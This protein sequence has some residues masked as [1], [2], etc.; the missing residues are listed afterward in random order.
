MGSIAA[1]L[2]IAF[3]IMGFIS[4]FWTVYLFFKHDDPWWSTISVIIFLV[5]K[6]KLLFLLSIFAVILYWSEETVFV[7]FHLVFYV[8]TV[9]FFVISAIFDDNQGY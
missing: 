9:L 5:S 6:G 8:I 1:L 2:N 7:N 4:T 3:Q